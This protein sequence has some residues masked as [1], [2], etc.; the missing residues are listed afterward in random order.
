MDVAV[1]DGVIS[2]IAP[3]ISGEVFTAE[4]DPRPRGW[5]PESAG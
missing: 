1:A 4:W 5:T 3:Y 2:Q